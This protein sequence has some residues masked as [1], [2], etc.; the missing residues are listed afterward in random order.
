MKRIFARGLIISGDYTLAPDIEA[1]WFIDPPY[2]EDAG[3]G[4]KYGSKLIDYKKL[5]EWAKNR[6]GEVIFCEGHC[7]DYY[8]S[9]HYY[10]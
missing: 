7:G 10:I 3:K 8:H 2:K 9:S 4:Y 6:K 5:A 1:T